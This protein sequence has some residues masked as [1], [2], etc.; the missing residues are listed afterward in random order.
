MTFVYSPAHPIKE[1]QVLQTIAENSAAAS[2]R[3]K[4]LL[5]TRFDRLLTFTLWDFDHSLALGH[6]LSFFRCH[7]VH[8]C[9]NDPSYEHGR[10][11]IERIFSLLQL[12]TCPHMLTTSTVSIHQSILSIE[13]SFMGSRSCKLTSFVDSYVSATG[14]VVLSRLSSRPWPHHLS[15]RQT[16]RFKQAPH[17]QPVADPQNSEHSPSPSPRLHT[18]PAIPLRQPWVAP[19]WL[20]AA[21][22]SREKTISSQYNG[23]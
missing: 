10:A 7:A 23:I 5:V 6:Y 16:S 20:E 13:L 3:P 18:S 11:R 4:K 21:G 1:I 9:L 15:L 19:N 12:S 17:A 8:H 22:S 14:E 2:P